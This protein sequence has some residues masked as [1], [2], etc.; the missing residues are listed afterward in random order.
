MQVT[1]PLMGKV[2]VVF[3]AARAAGKGVAEELCLAGATVYCVGRST[4]DAPHAGDLRTSV[5]ATV[6]R[7]NRY[8][9]NKA[10]PAYV[11]A[12][13]DDAVQALFARV[14][15]EQGRLDILANSIWGYGSEGWARPFWQQSVSAG[16]DLIQRAA[17]AHIL[18]LVHAIPLIADSPEPGLIVSISDVLGIG[19]YDD[20]GHIMQH[21]LA[22]SLRIE[23]ER[24][25]VNLTAVTLIP[26][27]LRLEESIEDAKVAPENWPD[28]MPGDPDWLN[29][30]TPRYTGRAVV[31]LACDPKA[32]EKTG[33]VL[34]TRELAREYG[35]TDTDGRQP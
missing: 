17:R 2:A 20:L 5:D 12:T 26:G 15:S 31:A 14:R 1:T 24:G 10:L 22:E 8:S 34:E 13:N 33:R 4:Y 6:E 11:D 7:L 16:L 27:W 29:S 21:R 9:A 30:Q 32:Q 18:P 19:L 28:I 23:A 25:A 3:G 35:F